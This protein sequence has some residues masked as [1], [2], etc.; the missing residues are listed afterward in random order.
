[1]LSETE[2]EIKAEIKAEIEAGIKAGNVE[3]GDI[4]FAPGTR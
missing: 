1:V 3:A 4:Q 2:A